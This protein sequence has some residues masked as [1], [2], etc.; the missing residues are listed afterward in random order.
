MVI[1]GR[2]LAA[3]IISDLQ[4]EFKDLAEVKVFVLMV[5]DDPASFSFLRQK[6]KTAQRVEVELIVE[7]LPAD[8][9]EKVLLARIGELNEIPE[10]HG[11][12][13]QLPLPDGFNIE[14]AL[15]SISSDKDIDG[16][17]QKALVLAPAVKVVEFLFKKYQ[18]NWQ[19]AKIVLVGYGCLVG[20]PVGK[21]LNKKSVEF[22]VIDKSTSEPEK[23]KLIKA[24]DIIISGVGRTGLV[25]ASWVKQAS[26]VIDF[27]CD[28]SAGQVLGDVSKEA[29]LRARLFTPTP[30]GTGPILTALLFHNLLL[31]T[32]R[33]KF[34]NISKVRNFNFQTL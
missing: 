33:K 32:K 20:E 14:K 5:G 11:I 12:I 6:Q 10:V 1:N 21:W 19:K 22:S 2:Q 3:V 26:V 23:E 9:G 8:C 15:N 13:V 31:L 34:A 30:G 28:F 7:K 18:V 17:G 24:A 29:A 16:L 27:G 25:S 4:K